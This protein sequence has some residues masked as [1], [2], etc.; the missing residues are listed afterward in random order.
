M[1]YSTKATLVVGRGRARRARRPDNR[2]FSFI[3]IM[4]VVVIIGLLAGAVVVKVGGYME[5]AKTNRARS[6]IATIVDAVE[7]YHLQNGRYPTNDEGLKNLPLKNRTDP[8]GKAYEYNCPGH[9]EPFEVVSFGADGREGG[10]GADTDI[11]SSQLEEKPK[12]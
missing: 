10:D 6:D 7:A 4:V 9:N 1:S 8:W 3:E 5:T 12:K 2:G 11:L